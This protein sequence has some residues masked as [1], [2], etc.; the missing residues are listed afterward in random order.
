MS[1]GV[2]MVGSDDGGSNDGSGGPQ[3]SEHGTHGPKFPLGAVVTVVGW[4]LFLFLFGIAVGEVSIT[5]FIV[6]ALPV[7]FIIGISA[8]VMRAELHTKEDRRQLWLFFLTVYT[9]ATGI[10]LVVELQ[11]I[12]VQDAGFEILV[13]G[14]T[15]IAW[16]PILFVFV[17]VFLAIF[18]LPIKFGGR[19][20][21]SML[22]CFGLVLLFLMVIPEPVEFQEDNLPAA[23]R[24]E[25]SFGDGTN[26]VFNIPKWQRSIS[27][28]DGGFLPFGVQL[29]ALTMGL[30]LGGLWGHL[31]PNGFRRAFGLKPWEDEVAPETR[32]PPSE[33]PELRLYG[34]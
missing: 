3:Y 30:I 27:R 15:D 6:T 31:S 22:V 23:L 14:V 2:S 10:F 1:T 34:K 12:E 25:P 8:N 11:Y 29:P 19:G 18:L 4:S 26:Y 9:L 21:E 20:Y 24:P 13:S 7:L 33:R 5:L 32:G 16:V 28:S 17:G